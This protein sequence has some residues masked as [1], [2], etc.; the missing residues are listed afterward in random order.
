MAANTDLHVLLDGEIRIWINEGGAISL[1][2][3]DH[4]DPVEM[5]EHEAESLIDILS[6]LVR[7][8]SGSWSEAKRY[9]LVPDRSDFNPVEHRRFLPQI[10]ISEIDDGRIRYR[11]VGTQI[12]DI[13]GFDFTGRYLDEMLDSNPPEPW[14]DHYAAAIANRA[15]VLGA[16]TEPTNTGGS[17]TYEFGIFPVSDGGDTIRQFVCVEDYFGFNLT[18]ARLLRRWIQR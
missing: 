17:F 9:R 6:E 5:N 14:L 11:L 10:L 18:S 16:A 8:C 13:A 7:K 4:N 15:P 1:I 3:H 2:A 12:A